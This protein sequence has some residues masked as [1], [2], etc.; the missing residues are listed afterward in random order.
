MHSYFIFNN[1]NSTSRKILMEHAAPI[2]RGEERVTNIAIPGR[3]GDLTVVEGEDIYNPYIQ[4]IVINVPGTELASVRAWLRGSGWLTFSNDSTK[5]QQARVINQIT[6]E[7]IPHAINWYRAEVE[8]YCQPIKRLLTDPSGAI[9]SGG[10]IKN[11]GDL[12]MYPLITLTGSGDMTVSVLQKTLSIASV[13]NG[14]C[15]I[16]CEAQIVTNGAGT[17]SLMASVSGDF[18]VVP[19]GTTYTLTFTGATTCTVVRKQRYL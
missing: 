7:K 4:N 9:T 13:P 12:P 17:E 8:F 14:G 16:D 10:Y 6:F 1:V 11:E 3:A 18:P 19:V 5:R 2:I 15:I